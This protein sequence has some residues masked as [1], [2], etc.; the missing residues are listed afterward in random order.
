M[1]SRLA[2]SLLFILI[3][4]NFT[5][6]AIAAFERYKSWTGKVCVRGAFQVRDRLMP[7]ES[8]PARA[9]QGNDKDKGTMNQLDGKRLP[10]QQNCGANQSRLARTI[11]PDNIIAFNSG[12]ASELV[13]SEEGHRQG[14]LFKLIG[15]HYLNEAFDFITTGARQIHELLSLISLK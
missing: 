3:A 6:N 10:I 2:V 11:S 5:S 7:R 9:I 4:A 13:S 12:N 8:A 15:A 14:I 1:K